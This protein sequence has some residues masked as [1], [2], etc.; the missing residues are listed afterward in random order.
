MNALIIIGIT[1]SLLLGVVM[2]ISTYNFI[3][4]GIAFAISLIY[5]FAMA[6][7][8]YK[9]HIKKV[10]R[11]HECYHFINTFI[12]SLSIKSSIK[13]A[14]ESSFESMGD[15][16]LKEMEGMVELNENEKLNH[17]TQYFPFHI[18]GLFLNLINLWSEQGGNIIDMSTYLI[19]E[20]RLMEE[21]L[22]ESQRISRKNLLEFGVLW[23]FS[24]LILVIL[25]FALSQFY[26][27][28]STQIYF[29]IAILGI[30]V[31]LLITIHVALLRTTKIEIRGWQNGK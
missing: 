22:T 14:L 30:I 31:F 27:K 8:I 20:S 23:T 21:Y 13:G 6:L 19:N 7:P 29:P 2:F 5:F 18:Y 9:K 1:V 26:G 4:A 10:A 12:I 15:A 3:F 17:L 24:M 28:L 16:F 11:F 25:R